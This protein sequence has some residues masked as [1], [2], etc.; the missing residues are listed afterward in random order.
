MNPPRSGISHGE[1]KGPEEIRSL[2]KRMTSYPSI[3]SPL[4][5]LGDGDENAIDKIAKGILKMNQN[6]LESIGRDLID[7]ILDKELNT[8]EDEKSYFVPINAIRLLAKLAEKLVSVVKENVKNLLYYIHDSQDGYDHFNL[9]MA[10]ILS[11][12][13]DTCLP[14]FKEFYFNRKE[15]IWGRMRMCET[16]GKMASKNPEKFR[17]SVVALF[18][19]F[20]SQSDLQWEDPGLCGSTVSELLNLKAIEAEAVVKHAFQLNAVD[21][22]SCGGFGN[23]QIELHGK[24][25][26]DDPIVRQ[27]WR[28]TEERDLKEGK[29]F[30]QNLLNKK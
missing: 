28:G 13:D 23:W 9:Q 14:L 18:M 7:M 6:D 30:L 4:L 27:S 10:E 2:R 5:S 12:Q 21:L 3:L 22:D 24:L 29:N 17:E 19:E 20:L 11:F 1:D 15:Y 16:L 25:D 8:S 26:R